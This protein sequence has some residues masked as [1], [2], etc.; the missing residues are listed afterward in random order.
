MWAGLHGLKPGRQQ[1]A[2]QVN[3]HTLCLCVG[4]GVQL[5]MQGTGRAA[6]PCDAICCVLL[7]RSALRLHRDLQTSKVHITLQFRP[8]LADVS[9]Q[10][11]QH[12]QG[13]RLCG[14]MPSMQPCFEFQAQAVH[15]QL[16]VLCCCVFVCSCR[17]P[18]QSGQ[19]PLPP[20]TMRCAGLWQ[21]CALVQ[22]GMGAF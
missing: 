1:Y 4:G 6:A 11:H 7:A 15:E 14:G 17:A 20:S 13:P 22:G 18:L 12:Q 2:R 19:T 10:R 21:L 9:A 16:L 8:V 5:P 3:S